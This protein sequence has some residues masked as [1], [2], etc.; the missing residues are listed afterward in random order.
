MAH[1]AALGEAR[2]VDLAGGP[3]AY[4]ERGEGPPVVFVHGLLVNGDLWRHVVPAVAEA[5]FRCITPDWPLGSHEHPMAEDADLSPGGVAGLVASFL[6]RLS[7]TEVTLVA[8]DTGGAITQLVMTRHPDRVGRVVLTSSDAFERF[9]PPLFRPLQWLAR[10]PGGV[11]LVVHA[12]RARALH[13]LPMAFG[14][15]AKRPIPADVVESYLA[16]SRRRAEVRRDLRRFLRAVDNRVTLAAAR[17]LPR[18]AAPVLLA[19]AA[20]DRLFP[21]SLARRLAELLPDAELV[22]VD[23][24]YTFLPED[25]PSRLSEL[26]VDFLRSTTPAGRIPSQ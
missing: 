3:I 12:L 9:F 10:V 14:W 15:V 2:M 24:S 19:W 8:N 22:T 20:E 16:P 13:R 5:G 26:I 17:D 1:S 18:F 25:Q 6:E 4:R 21:V 23:D 7:L 11:P